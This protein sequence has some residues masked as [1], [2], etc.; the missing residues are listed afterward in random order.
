MAYGENGSVVGP[1][2]LPTRSVA[3]GVWSLG[4]LSE[5]QRDG[6]WPNPLFGWVAQFDVDGTPGGSQGATNARSISID[7]SDHIFAS[8][9]AAS[10]DPWALEVDEDGVYQEAAYTVP[11]SPSS[12][13]RLTSSVIDSAG[14]LITAG[15][16]K[17]QN[18][19]TNPYIFTMMKLNSSL[20]GVFQYGRGM[21]YQSRECIF[22][23]YVS[24]GLGS[25]IYASGNVGYHQTIYE[26][27]GQYRNE[28]FFGQVTVSSGYPLYPNKR[29]H[30][31]YGVNLKSLGVTGNDTETWGAWTNPNSGTGQLRLASLG[32]STK[33]GYYPPSSSKV[34]QANLIEADS[35]GSATDILAYCQW[36]ASEYTTL[37][38]I[39]KSTGAIV[40]QRDITSTD[41]AGGLAWANTVCGPIL[42]S[43]GNIYVSWADYNPNGANGAGFRVSWAKYSSAGVFQFARSMSQTTNVGSSARGID[44]KIDSAE[45]NLIILFLSGVYNQQGMFMVPLNGDGA[46]GSADVIA[47]D[48]VSKNFIYE[49]LSYA[50]RTGIMTK[51][52]GGISGTASNVSM[53]SVNM[54]SE[55]FLDAAS[56]D[57]YDVGGVS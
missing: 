30:D 39:T 47:N 1:Q 52:S 3:S 31:N 11:T 8:G 36:S 40:W 18:V 32:G 7:S 29:I 42:D 23:D 6:T 10:Y 51:D 5:A 2:N 22:T 24:P 54:T 4:E 41:G 26:N 37:V 14:D 55:T 46:G 19:Y 45:E 13:I 16:Y 35:T 25:E 12:L 48:G 43:S 53:T 57:D 33:Y 9:W 56:V 27:T 38:K 21:H 44:M 34:N 49:N 17:D 28:F 15:S 50:T 20:T